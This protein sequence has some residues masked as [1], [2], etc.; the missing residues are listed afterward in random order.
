MKILLLLLMLS[1][2]TPA[3]GV[4]VYDSWEECRAAVVTHVRADGG[5]MQMA[6]SAFICVAEGNTLR[7]V[8]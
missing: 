8:K 3:I 5:Q 6:G 7:Q 1:R 2:G 4:A